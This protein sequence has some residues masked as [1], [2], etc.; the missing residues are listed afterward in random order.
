MGYCSDVLIIYHGP[1]EVVQAFAVAAK[2]GGHEKAIA[3]MSFKDSLDDCALGVRFNDVKWYT[4]Y[5]DV[6]IH[7]DLWDYAQEFENLS[8]SFCRIGEEDDDNEKRSFGEAFDP[9]SLNRSISCDYDF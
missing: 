4:L 9:I 2:L 7:E 1:K 8:G 5:P 3:E 6:K